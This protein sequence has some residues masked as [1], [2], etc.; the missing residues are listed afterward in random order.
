VYCHT[1]ITASLRDIVTKRKKTAEA[2]ISEGDWIFFGLGNY[3]V[4][5]PLVVNANA[6]TKITFQSTDINYIQNKGQTL[7][8]DYTAQKFLPQTLNDVYLVE[9]R[10]KAKC[11]SQNGFGTIKL[12]S[13]T[14]GFNPLQAQT[15][16]APRAA[17]Q[18]QFMSIAVPVYIGEEVLANGL[19]VKWHSESGNFSLYDVSFMIVKLSSGK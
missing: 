9:I 19:E 4:G 18:E 17:N 8:Y 13:P 7:N 11:S 2:I 3:T 5:S 12:E 10:F 1:S 16:G 6:T 15:M 14:F